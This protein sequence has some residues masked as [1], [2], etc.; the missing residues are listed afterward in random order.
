MKQRADDY[1]RIERAISFIEENFKFQPSLDSVAG[2]VNLSKFHF[3]RLFKR[4]AGISPKQF[5]QFLTLEYAKNRLAQ[6]QSVLDATYDSGLSGPGR[7]HDLFVT[8]DA[9]TPGEYKSMGAGLTIQ[10][11]FHPTPF[12]M[13]LIAI[14]DKG[15]CF[16]GFL[17]EKNNQED[18]INS[19]RKNWPGAILK[20]NVYRTDQLMKKI[21]GPENH[22]LEKPFNL[23][24]KGTNF[25]I[26]V[27]RA[28]LRIPLGKF[29][30]YEDI[31]K[32]IGHPESLRAVAN[33][34]AVNPISYLIPCHRVISKTGNFHQYRWGQIRKRAILGWE[35]A[36]V[37]K[38][39]PV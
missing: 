28:L 23:A 36:N 30:C 3:D 25:Q 15:I 11:G 8:F 7:L 33:A 6:S 31:A 16:F 27:W 4:W 10:Y 9:V 29:V 19:L 22:Q 1:Y 2:A 35:A 39:D 5:M 20:E 17:D 38:T 32:Y 21:F 26:N 18:M 34:V 13:S 24:I 14:T 37:S 12:G